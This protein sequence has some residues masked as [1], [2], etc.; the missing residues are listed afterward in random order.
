VSTPRVVIIGA[1]VVGVGLADELTERGWTNVTVVDQGPLWA[2]GGSTSHAP[3]LIAKDAILGGYLVPTDGL[4]K[5]LRIVEFMG[6]RSRERGAVIQGDTRVT[7]IRTDD[8]RVR[9]V[10]TDQG[11]IPADIVVSAAGLWG[12]VIGAMVGQP[13]AL[14]QTAPG[15]QP[16]SLPFTPADFEE[17][18]ASAQELIPALRGAAIEH[19]FNGIFSFTPDG[20]PL[21]G[22]SRDVKGLWVAEAVW[23]TH[24]AGVARAMAQWLVDGQAHID[25]HESDLHRFEPHHTGPAF[26]EARGRQRDARMRPCGGASC[27]S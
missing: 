12:P 9:A 23:V 15:L 24:S 14:P 25:V 22:E 3:G 11:E 21:M 8:G 10:L 2:A 16:A 5:A 19:A 20:Y 7:G 27:R 4:A 6:R 17:S 26:V 18:W 1:G 13:I